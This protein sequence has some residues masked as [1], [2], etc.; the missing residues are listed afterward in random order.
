MKLKTQGILSV[1]DLKQANAETLR[2][3]YSVLMEKTVRE[4]N[5]ISCLELE[6]SISDKKQILSSRSFGIPVTDMNSL[7]ESISLYTSRA[8]VKLRRQYSVARMI[9]VYIRTSPYREG[10]AYYGNSMMVPLPMASDDTRVLVKH[11]L[12]A[13]KQMYRHGFNYAKAGIMLTELQ[14]K[15]GQQQ[16]LFALNQDPKSGKLMTVMDNINACMGKDALQLANQGFKRPWKMKQE[17]KSPG[18]TTRWQDLLS[19]R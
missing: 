11:A 15:S 8:A 2:R 6:Y 5:G 10:D 3:Q 13:L 19:V 12:T 9:Q 17:R 18:Y 14:P 16:D 4:L 1:L 7:A